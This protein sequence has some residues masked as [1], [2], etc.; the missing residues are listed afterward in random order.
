MKDE[1]GKA[2]RNLGFKKFANL[3]RKHVDP[4]FS[5][6]NNTKS[7]GGQV[8]KDF[9]FEELAG[10]II[11]D[12]TYTITEDQYRAFAKEAGIDIPKPAPAPAPKPAPLLWYHS[13]QRKR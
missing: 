12:G 11:G 2:F 4:S 6:A 1:I 13:P 8:D 10:Y 5:R 7:V 9:T 3:F